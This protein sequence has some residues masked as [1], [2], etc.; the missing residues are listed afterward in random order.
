MPAKSTLHKD[1]AVQS[2]SISVEQKRKEDNEDIKF[3]EKGTIFITSHN[4]NDI[5]DIRIHLA[6]YK[7]TERAQ[8][9]VKVQKR[10]KKMVGDFAKNKETQESNEK[11]YETLV[12]EK[13]AAKQSYDETV[14]QKP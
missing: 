12:K 10:M 3:I 8:K 5:K 2:K 11:L 1:P 13:L 6:S 7:R 4:I 9:Y 14:L